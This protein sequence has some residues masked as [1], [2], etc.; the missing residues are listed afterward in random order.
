MPLD[1][2]S[3][4]AGAAITLAVGK[5]YQFATHL[6]TRPSLD[7]YYREGS[8]GCIETRESTTAPTPPPSP[9][10]PYKLS[11]PCRYVRLTVTNT[12]RESAIACR[13]LLVGIEKADD[14]GKFTQRLFDSIPLCWSYLPPDAP[15]RIDL[16]RRVKFN[17]DLFSTK[18]DEK[19]FT[20]RTV[21]MP[22]YYKFDDPGLFRFSV[23]VVADNAPA[24]VAQLLL[25]WRS[26]WND[27]D[28]ERV[29]VPDLPRGAYD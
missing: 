9:S 27:F 20:P 16:P 4:A 22:N 8:Y 11:W 15:Q 14:R 6:G 13:G 7:V 5:A 17:L 21:S 1:V 23:V 18:F 12:G 25:Q 24:Q 3:V 26:K 28:I 19:D 10:L 2:L 29:R